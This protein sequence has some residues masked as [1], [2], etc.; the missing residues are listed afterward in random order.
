MHLLFLLS[1]QHIK[2]RSNQDRRP[3]SRKHTSRNPD[4]QPR[5]ALQTTRRSS[6]VHRNDRIRTRRSRQRIRRRSRQRR[7]RRRRRRTESHDRNP[8]IQLRQRRPR[9]QTLPHTIPGAGAGWEWRSRAETCVGQ[10]RDFVVGVVLAFFGEGRGAG[11]ESECGV[12]LGG[13]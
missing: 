4:P 8:K 11:G 3:S 13:C 7:I 9:L 12:G 2:K 6:P 10:R 1:L 5:H